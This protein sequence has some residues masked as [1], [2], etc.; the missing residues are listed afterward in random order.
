MKYEQ[1]NTNLDYKMV[2]SQIVLIEL[3]LFYL[4]I[5][6]K[7]LLLGKSQ[8]KLKKGIRSRIIDQDLIPF[9]AWDLLPSA[10]TYFIQSVR[11]CPFSCVF[12]MNHNVK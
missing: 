8:V 7:V 3:Y 6:L 2:S 1:L 5:E 11:G 4:R 12:C 10:N 9:P